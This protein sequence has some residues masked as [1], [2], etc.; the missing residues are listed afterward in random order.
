MKVIAALIVALLTVGTLAPAHALP[1][2]TASKDVVYTASST[3]GLRVSKLDVTTGLVWLT[4]ITGAP[5]DL[6]MSLTL[7][8]EVL[9]VTGASDSIAPN[10]GFVWAID[11]ATGQILWRTDIATGG[12]I[13]SSATVERGVVYVAG[14]VA[15]GTGRTTALDAATGQILW[16]T[17]AVP[18]LPLYS[19]P[20]VEKDVV[21]VVTGGPPGIP[22]VVITMDALSG[23]ILR[24]I[25]AP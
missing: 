6:V 15:Q 14:T 11:T 23:V 7:D 1:N 19:S 4:N 3:A 12:A 22:V 2:Y 9:Y 8:K 20:T 24:A 21:T 18:G 10:T 17:V 13:Y 16:T 5:L 25:P